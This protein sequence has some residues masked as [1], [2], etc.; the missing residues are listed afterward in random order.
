MQAYCM[1]ITQLST[2]VAMVTS[3][4]RSNLVETEG[5]ADITSLTGDSLTPA[6]TPHFLG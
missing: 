2:S 4:T 6:H 5:N 3:S 1:G